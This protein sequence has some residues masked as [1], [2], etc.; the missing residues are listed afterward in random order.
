VTAPSTEGLD[1]F[2][3][4]ERFASR[5]LFAGGVV[6]LA[7]GA[8]LTADH[9]LP[10]ML[11]VGWACVLGLSKAGLA[12][13]AVRAGWR[14]WPALLLEAAAFAAVA[15]LVTGAGEAAGLVLLLAAAA[16][17]G[18]AGWVRRRAATATVSDEADE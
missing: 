2:E 11:L 12:V 15:Y 17:L 14:A 9:R 13:V 7:L 10:P 6:A 8:L 1:R 4:R 16:C 5:A 18:G 3:R